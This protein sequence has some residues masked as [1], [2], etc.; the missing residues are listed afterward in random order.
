MA[1]C[2]IIRF[3]IDGIAN[4]HIDLCT[5]RIRR[6][7]KRDWIAA[8]LVPG[9]L[10]WTLFVAIIKWAMKKLPP[11]KVLMARAQL[12][13]LTTG[14]GFTFI[15][16]WRFEETNNDVRAVAMYIFDQR[17]FG[18]RYKAVSYCCSSRPHKRWEIGCQ[19]RQTS[20]FEFVRRWIFY[21]DQ[22]WR[23]FRRLWL[24][25]GSFAW[26]QPHCKRVAIDG[27]YFEIH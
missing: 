21:I 13:F 26:S 11:I 14:Y 18:L 22:F 10:S 9:V 7:H 23:F 19:C 24:D 15:N 17:L 27:A 3:R 6:I 20:T 4:H 25:C 16:S 1:G 8:D 5:H 12:L 2:F